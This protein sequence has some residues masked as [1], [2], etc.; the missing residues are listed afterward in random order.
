M[1]KALKDRTQ[2]L[3]KR[4]L[5]FQQNCAQS[6]EIIRYPDIPGRHYSLRTK[7]SE[8]TPMSSRFLRLQEQNRSNNIHV[9]CYCFQGQKVAFPTALHSTILDGNEYLRCDF[10]LIIIVKVRNSY[11]GFQKSKLAHAWKSHQIIAFK[12]WKFAPVDLWVPTER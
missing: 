7:A 2:R 11:S 4:S 5:P 6:S 12:T 9:T 3:I 10:V 1:A 8:I